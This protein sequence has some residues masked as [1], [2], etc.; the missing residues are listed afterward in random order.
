MLCIMLVGLII[1]YIFELS[2]YYNVLMC[3]AK[4]LSSYLYFLHLYQGF[5]V[6]LK[7]LPRGFLIF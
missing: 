3:A 6:K 7:Q 5:S 4:Y 2:I 1:I